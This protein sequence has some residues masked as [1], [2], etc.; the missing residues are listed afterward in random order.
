[1]MREPEPQV[2][3]RPKAGAVADPRWWVPALEACLLLLVAAT[4]L[5]LASKFEFGSLSVV[6]YLVVSG[7]VLV[8]IVRALRY[9]DF[10]LAAYIFYIPFSKTIPGIVGPGLNITNA[11]LVF[12]GLAG[13]IAR[14]RAPG[15][16][17][18]PTFRVVALW[19]VFSMA[20]FGTAISA[21]GMEWFK[22]NA[23]P[24]AWEWS[25]QFV[26]FFAALSILRDPA[27][28]RR[29][30]VYLVV[31]MFPVLVGGF[32]EW[33]DK[34]WSNSIEEGR[35]IGPHLQPNAFAGFLVYGASLPIAFGLANLGRVSSWF[36]GVP[37]LL[38]FLRILLATFSRGA[39]IGFG[40]AVTILSLGRGIRFTLLIACLGAATFLT[41]PQLLPSSL[42]DRMEQTSSSSADFE[43]DLD[44]S[45]K[46]RLVL[47]QAAIDMTLESPLLGK[48][49]GTFPAL[50]GEYTEVDVRE[51]DNHNMFLY[52]CSQ[53]GL[54]TLAVFL[55]VFAR[56]AQLGLSLAWRGG[57]PFE[58]AIGMAA[59]GTAAAVM[60]VNMF[61]S[62]M[63]DLNCMAYV[64]ILLALTGRVWASRS[65]PRSG[66]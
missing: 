4:A 20:S 56:M 13:L 8:L 62:R 63:T 2:L 39:Y 59:M 66:P 18:V 3:A 49:F 42:R 23:A 36:L 48:G 37:A 60:G 17:T 15:K 65:R 26:F 58:S 50:K 1:M 12:V 40:M 33:L 5:F 52:I 61:G 55:I 24:R 41:F 44:A 21:M 29:T 46:T 7:C 6:V 25:V 31:G 32:D 28:M 43:E 54:P 22:E 45:S 64:W 34:R 51:S 27:A 11:L 35:V 14:A 38:V 9:P 16:N 57:T 10:A 47:W 30:T 19:A 53:M